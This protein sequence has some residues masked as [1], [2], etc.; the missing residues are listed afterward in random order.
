MADEDHNLQNEANEVKDEVDSAFEDLLNFNLIED[1]GM[2][3]DV[4]YLW[5]LWADF[6]L[7]I[8]KPFVTPRP[9]KIVEPGKDPQSGLPEDVYPIYDYGDVFR[10][11]RGQDIAK[12]MRVTRKYLNTVDKIIRLASQRAKEVEDETGVGEAE[13]ERRVAFRGHEIGQRKG[14]ISAIN[15]DKQMVVV[16]FEPGEWG[17]RYLSVLDE[18]IKRGYAERPGMKPGS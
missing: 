12:G 14:F 9:V 8:T 10:T 17:E 16:N 11:S 13:P 5:I 1:V 4:Y 7:F 6:H 2:L 18:L 3:Q 15:H